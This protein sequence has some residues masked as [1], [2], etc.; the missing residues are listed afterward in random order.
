VEIFFFEFYARCG[1]LFKDVNDI[2]AMAHSN[3][4]VFDKTGTLTSGIL[5]VKRLAPLSG[6]DNTELLKTAAQ[7]EFGSRHPVAVSICELARRV[8][9]PFGMPDRIHE[10]PGRGVK[11]TLGADDIIAG[12]LPWALD[13]G[14]R[15][16][17]FPDLEA[18][19]AEGMSMIFVLRNGKPLGWIGL[20]DHPRDEARDAL[21]ELAALGIGHIAMVSGDRN[22]VVNSVAATL[23]V[24]HI[25][26]EC[27]PADK[28][29]YINRVKA[30]GAQ[31][32]FIGDGVNDA[33][34]LAA[35]R[36]GIAMGAAGSDIAINSATIA[37]MNNDLNRLPFLLRLARGLR[38]TIFQNFI[39][40]GVII[41]G[42]FTFSALGQLSPVL[43]AVLQV[44]GAAIVALNSARLIRM[45]EEL[46][47]MPVVSRTGVGPI[48][49]EVKA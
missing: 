18:A 21:A 32:V 23:N 45:G 40:G 26:G 43:A 27:S 29:D 25:A 9:L 47:I 37:L 36:I 8:N 4:F 22:A 16:E 44:C 14:A 48:A 31:V 17:D 5:E 35:S 1:V 41:V 20:G 34:A 28:V 6:I 49:L 11:A 39:I 30:D 13:N 2:E 10:E 12:N 15:K 42:G 3:A 46:Q 7:A 38:L 19:L 24:R 33:P